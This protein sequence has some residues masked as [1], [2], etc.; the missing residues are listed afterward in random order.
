MRKLLN[1]NKNWIFENSEVCLPHTAIE[2]PFNYFD[3][4][5]YQREFIYEKIIIPNSTWDNK[6]ISVVFEAVMANTQ[7]FLNNKKIVSHTDGYSPFIARL[8]DELKKGENILKVKIDGSENPSIPP[9]GGRI[10]YLTYAG[11]YRDVNLRI[12]SQIFT[13][14]IKIETPNILDEK[15]S[16]KVNVYLFNPKKLTLSGFLIAK[17][18]DTNGL[19]LIHI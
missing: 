19:S 12:T 16:L 15:K 17:L 8:T 18:K 6:E 13:Q 2:L 7:V 1:F 5:T 14:N 9:F 3:E 10:D 11:I 4:K